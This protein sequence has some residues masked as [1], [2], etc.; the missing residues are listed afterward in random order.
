[1]NKPSLSY[2]G[3][4]VGHIQGIATD[5]NREFMYYSCT[6][7]LAKTDME[8]NVIGTVK[9]LAGH[10]GCIAYNY[11]N[12]KI[13]GSLEYKH[14]AIG[15]HILKGLSEQSSSNVEV[16]DGFYIAIFD[17]DK[18]DRMDMDA[19]KDGV[20][21][22]VFLKEVFDDFSAPNHKYACS[23]IDGLTFAPLP[24]EKGKKYLYVGYGVYGD[25]NRTDNDYQVLLRYDIDGWERYAKPLSQENMHRL[26]PS[27]PDDKYF[28]YTGNTVYGVQNLE[29]DEHTGYAFAAVYCGQ[30]AEFPNYP[31]Y[32]IDFNI[33]AKLAPLTGLNEQGKTLTL[34]SV[35]VRDEKTGICGIRFPYGATG[36]QSLGDGY[37]Y[38][39]KD[40]RNESGCG[41]NVALFRF[42]KDTFIEC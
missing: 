22:V 42:E 30:K 5:K 37:F 17:V 38:F 21:K 16:Q 7:F 12:G 19:E 27:K 29:Y 41:T 8:G 11:E 20:M 23:G 18:I 14:D 24:G 33:P 4:T 39:S 6:T 36:M 1:M 10:L 15:N 26:G 13:Y 25:V 28:V 40:F 35:G 3:I 34:A 31:M 9:G 32:V 2:G